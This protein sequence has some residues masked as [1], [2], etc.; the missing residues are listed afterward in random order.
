[1][2]SVTELQPSEVACV[3]YAQ[4][5]NEFEEISKSST[6]AHLVRRVEAI[7]RAFKGN[8]GINLDTTLD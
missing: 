7:E 5:L 2:V 8:V 4:A 3:R 6:L 1:V